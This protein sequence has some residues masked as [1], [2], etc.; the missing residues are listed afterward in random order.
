MAARPLRSIAQILR[1]EFCSAE[2]ET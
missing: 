2:C 1:R